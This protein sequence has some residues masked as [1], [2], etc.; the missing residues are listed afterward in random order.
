MDK[1]KRERTQS[2]KRDYDK[3]LKEV[4]SEALKNINPEILQAIEL[5]QKMNMNQ[6]TQIQVEISNSGTLI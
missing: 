5:V 1:T 6:T 4:L 3:E 2:M